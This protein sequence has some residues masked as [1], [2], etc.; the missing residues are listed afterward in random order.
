[1][2]LLLLAGNDIPPSSHI[3]ACRPAHSDDCTYRSC[4]RGPGTRMRVSS[5]GE[6]KIKSFFFFCWWVI[7]ST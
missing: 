1:M 7:T 2:Y 6:Q 4:S 3:R 5:L